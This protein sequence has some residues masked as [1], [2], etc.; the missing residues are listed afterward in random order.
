MKFDFSEE[1]L[2]LMLSA[3]CLYKK[4]INDCYLHNLGFLSDAKSGKIMVDDEDLSACEIMVHKDINRIQMLESVY[5]KLF[6][7]LYES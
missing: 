7:C 5:N 2:D 4:Q 6:A 1:E 3:V